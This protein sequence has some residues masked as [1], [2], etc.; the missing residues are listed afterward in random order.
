MFLKKPFERFLGRTE[1]SSNKAEGGAVNPEISEDDKKL[2]EMLRENCGEPLENAKKM[3]V[4][5][6]KRLME[7]FKTTDLV[8]VT[9]IEQYKEMVKKGFIL[10][11]G[12][13]RIY[14]DQKPG[15]PSDRERTNLHLGIDCVVENGSPVFAIYDGEVMGMEVV[16]KNKQELFE[17]NGQG[18]YRGEGGYGNMI[19]LRHELGEK[20]FYSLY[21]HLAAP[22][23]I[24]IIGDLIKKGEII[25]TVGKSFSLENGGWPAHLHFNI[26]KEQNA[27]A[28]YGSE[29]D[30]KKIIDPI[31]IFK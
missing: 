2:I 3:P 22:E 26:L 27:V 24:P 20:T 28:G 17:N 12:E 4:Y 23:K 31:K 15:Q 25:G 8:A 9:E 10:K 21:G 1:N 16:D 6:F 19:L 29:D 11:S 13:E 18:L 30:L 7:K 14:Y 5:L